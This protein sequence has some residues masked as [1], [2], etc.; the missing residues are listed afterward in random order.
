MDVKHLLDG[1]LKL[2]HLVLVAAIDDF[3]SL[4][5]AARH[6]HITQPAVTRT[7]RELEAILEVNLFDRGTHGAQPTPSGEVFLEH[8]RA[9]LRN[10]ITAGEQLTEMNRVGVQPVRVGTNLAAAYSLLPNALVNLKRDHSVI[11]VCVIEG[12]QDDLDTRLLRGDVDLL[13]GRLQPDSNQ[14]FRHVPLYDEPV[15]IVVRRGHPASLHSSWGLQDLLTF[16]WILPE[17][18]ATLR[19]EIDDLFN[20][21]GLALPID[22]IECSTILTLRSIL[23]QTDTVAPLPAS[24]GLSDDALVTLPI[25]LETVPRSIGIATLA[26]QPPS[27]SARTLIKYL[28][29]V[30]REISM[31]VGEAPWAL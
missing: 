15:G 19:G 17:G 13:V 14:P 3:G 26:E 16:P 2:R 7:L 21:R 22:L 28:V 24:I 6:F 27:A 10:L 25:P 8:A 4:A 30:A 29:A 12:T 9:V 18:P 5:G 31:Q 11:T 1:R 20:R 23:L